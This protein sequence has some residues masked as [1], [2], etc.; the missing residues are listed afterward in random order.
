PL[1]GAR[2]ACH[3]FSLRTVESGLGVVPPTTGI[4][5]TPGIGPTGP[6]SPPQ[7]AG[8]SADSCCAACCTRVSQT[9]VCKDGRP[10]PADGV[11][12]QTC[13]DGTQIPEAMACSTPP[14]PSVCPGGMVGTPP[15]CYCPP[16]T[17][18]DP[19]GRRCV[20]TTTPPP[21][22]CPGGMLGT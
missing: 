22:V 4:T 11:C 2:Y 17:E 18:W 20:P 1:T 14:S 13:A 21:S 3:R 8:Q 7:A 10:V 16:N 9:A 12:M 6:W 5:D 15:S 19:A